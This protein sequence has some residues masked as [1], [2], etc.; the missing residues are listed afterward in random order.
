MNT[1]RTTDRRLLV[2][3]AVLV[4]IS[5]GLGGFLIH[6]T[7]GEEDPMELMYTLWMNSKRDLL[8][9]KEDIG[10]LD[11]NGD[12]ND[13][14]P[15]TRRTG[16][17]LEWMQTLSEAED[18]ATSS[19]ALVDLNNDG[20]L[21]VVIASSGDLIYTLEPD[22]GFFWDY[23]YSDDVIEDLTLLCKDQNL[24]FMAPPIFSSVIAAD[25]NLGDTPE[26]IIGVKDGALCIGADGDKQWKKGLTTGHYFS[27]P[28]ITDLEGEWT[29]N[30]EDLEIILASDDAGKRGWLE[31]FEVDGGAI[32][33]E[34]V[35]TG[36]EGG[37]IGCSVVAQDLDGDFWDGPYLIDPEISRE[38]DTELII[39]N[40]DRGFRVWVRQGENAEGKPNYDESFSLQLLHQSYATSAIAN[41][42]GDPEIETFIGLSDGMDYQWT[43]WWGVL[44]CATPSGKINW[45][46]TLSGRP[47]SIFSSPAV[48]DLQLSKLSANEEHLDYEVVFG[49]DSGLLYVM[50]AEWHTPLWTFDTGG[51]ILSSPAICNIDNDGEC[52]I[53]IG[54][55]SR[56][57]FCLDGDPSDGVDDGEHYPGDG[58]DFD[59]LW[60]FE[61]EAPIGISSPAVADIDLDGMMEVVIGDSEGHVYCI[62]AGGRSLV[63]QEDWPQ[64]HCNLNRTG[65]YNPQISYGIDM[66]PKMGVDGSRDLMVRSAGPNSEVIY[67][68]TIENIGSGQT[69]LNRDMIYV[70]IEGNSVPEG[71]SAWLDTPAEKGNDD[72]D[73]VRLASQET[74]DLVLHVRTPWE[75]RIGEMTRINI[76]ANSSSDIFARDSITTMTVLDLCVDMDLQ[77]LKEVSMDPLNPLN[78]K[79]WDRVPPGREEVYTFSI[80]NR[81]SLNDTYDISLSEPPMDAG[82]DWFILGSDPL[83]ASARLSAQMLVEEFGG[84]SGKTFTVKVS[85]PAG[86]ARGTVI[87][88]QVRATSRV[89]QVSD[90]EEITRKDDLYLLV[91]E[92]SDISVKMDKDTKYVDPNGTVTYN[93]MV[94]NLGNKEMV[95]VLMVIDGKLPGWNI[96]HLSDPIRVYQGQTVNVPVR[97][98]APADA[99]AEMKLVSHLTVHDIGSPDIRTDCSFTT[100]VNQVFDLKA[101]VKDGKQVR[102]DPGTVKDI[103]IDILNM[104]NGDDVATLTAQEIPLEWNLTFQNAAGHDQR[105][106]DID[107]GSKMTVHGR[108]RVPEATRTG[109]YV[110]GISIEGIGS[111][112]TIYAVIFVNQTFDIDIRTYDG[113][114][115][116]TANIA[117]EVEKTFVYTVTNH[118]N[119]IDTVDIRIGS[120]Y[121][122]LSDSMGPLYYG[123]VGRISSVSNTPDQTCNI[124]TCD[125]GSPL[126]V[127]SSMT[128]VYYVHD[129][130]MGGSREI[131]E[132]TIILDMGQTAWVHV[133]LKAPGFETDN[134]EGVSIYLSASGMEDKDVM[135]CRFHILF[136]DL[137]FTTGIEV[138][139]PNND[140]RPKA[141]DTV[142]FLVKV[143]NTGDI[144]AE[145][146]EVQFLVDGVEKKVSTLRSLQHG[147]E[148]VKIVVFTWV[149][150]SGHHVIEMV[151]DSDNIIIE[152]HD[153]FVNGGE[154]DNNVARTV[155]DVKGSFILKELVNRNPV[156]STLLIIM[157]SVLALC[158]VAFLMR[159]KRTVP[160]QYRKRGMPS[161]IPHF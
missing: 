84:I 161:P 132:M 49:C 34:E 56:K 71:W 90:I 107:Q 99:K 106:F 98:R 103:H 5:L 66:Y 131:R 19:P 124:V 152:S 2:I 151:I 75:G 24:D 85:C 35:P 22:G 108:L 76:T 119:G 50:D 39:G 157:M 1:T 95:E 160:S 70:R 87:P 115:E 97:I 79:K 4:T 155:V 135:G 102:M 149:A 13:P 68:I 32:F 27:T 17:S 48:A 125:L 122:P 3:G 73:H 137:R 30:K 83:K 156:V 28:C 14:P 113:D 37:L 72:P 88:I 86:A 25:V 114:D 93:A 141:G 129:C 121:D 18:H 159:G 146:V 47:S 58:K 67:N 158:G 139:Y 52:E 143:E 123:W 110:M 77:W 41:V 26:I 100:I 133:T 53:I 144:S 147:T 36:G 130:S 142:T 112:M 21:E 148:D 136:P 154:A 16:G 10:P 138:S 120:G 64:F 45:K 153:Q 134:E 55:D 145:N 42:S 8:K 116:M 31:A 15:S 60:V 11:T 92:Q 46:Y 78:G 9:G 89:S 23:P 54:S 101:I 61:T 7:I 140:E 109:S 59:V 150:S 62:S 40:H 82:W 44:A 69:E 117:P 57:V 118:G 29:G 38:R 111:S 65:F 80:L 43:G 63:G 6:R 96:Y 81:G 33:R 74:A 94:S 127:S 105:T 12:T 104:G 126:V 128:D 20:D 91:G 51:R